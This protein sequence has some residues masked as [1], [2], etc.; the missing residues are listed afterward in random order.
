MNLNFCLRIQ[1][2]GPEFGANSMTNLPCVQAG[3]GGVMESE[4]F[5]WH[6]LGPLIPINHCLN[7][8]V[9]VWC[10]EREN[11]P[12]ATK[13]LRGKNREIIGAGKICNPMPKKEVKH[14]NP[15]TNG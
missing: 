7:A 3:G 13:V 8:T 5:S 15:K 6:T 11:Y 1:M 9:M 2:V 4:M 12:E 14:K 10:G